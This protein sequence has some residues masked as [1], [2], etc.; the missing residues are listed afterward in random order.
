M[1]RRVMLFSERDRDTALQ[2]LRTPSTFDLT[3]PELRACRDVID[4]CNHGTA[5]DEESALLARRLFDQ[6][7]TMAAEN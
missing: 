3:E 6:L 5:I 2:C 7:A 4:H 1:T